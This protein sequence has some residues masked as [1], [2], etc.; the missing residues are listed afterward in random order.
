MRALAATS[1]FTPPDPGDLLADYRAFVAGLACEAQAKRLRLRAA[2][3]F[4]ERFGDLDAWMRRSTPARLTDLDRTGAWPFITWCFVSEAAIPDVDLIGA[5]MK[6]SHFGAWARAHP[7]DVSRAQGA[8]TALSWKSAWSDQVCRMQLAFVCL[9]SGSDLDGLNVEILDA[10]AEQLG[11]AWSMTANHRRVVASRHAAL[12]QV[13]FQLGLVAPA[14]PHPNHRPRTVAD[15]AGRI[16]QP[17]IRAVVARYLTT[18][19]TTLR[20]A[21]VRDK[22]ENLE[23]FFVWLDDHHP[24]ILRLGGLTRSVVEEFLIWNHGRPSRGRRR[25][26]EPVSISRQHQAVSVLRTFTDDLIFWE[27]PDRPARPLVHT[28]DL[29][30]LPQHVPRALAPPVDVALMAGV[31][32]LDDV[33]ARSAIRILRGTGMRLGELIELELDC[34]L[35]FTGRGTWLRVPIGKLGTER[36]VPLD[37]DTL[38]AFDDWMAC[39]GRQRAVPHPRTGQPADLL[40]LIRGRKMGEGRIRKGLAEAVRNAGL[41]NHGGDPIHVTPHQLRHTYGTS[42][43]NG[44]MSL[45]ALMALLGHVTPE[46][47]L[48]YAHLASDTIRDAYADAM[49]KVRSRRPVLVAGAGGAFVSDRIQWLHAEMLKTRLTG[50]YC[51]RHPAA[52]ACPY[53]NVCEQCD[54]FTPGPEFTGPLTSQLADVINLR[55]DADDRGWDG[56]VDRHDRVI[57]S[58][59]T[60][61]DRL[62]RDAVGRPDG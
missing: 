21:T 7:A 8:A 2:E 29:P 25:R 4:S 55:D 32:Q 13:C 54:N 48:R 38:S 39:R 56:E 30:R 15:R 27:W 46:M 20:P 47:T 40:F 22:A 3:R 34:L 59:E 12:T 6:G 26:G 33:A 36:T 42:L 60:H 53:A 17:E 24:G 9:T 51:A 44:G 1:T 10:F 37:E 11:A 43:I 57:A 35:D 14:P 5:R 16:P 62:K 52:G 18:I 41:T 49:T 28:S 45:Q 23:L 19:A 31:A 58:L 61:L 50:G